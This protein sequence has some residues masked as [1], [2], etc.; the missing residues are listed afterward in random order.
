MPKDPR[1]FHEP[2]CTLTQL[3]PEGKDR[4]KWIGRRASERVTRPSRRRVGNALEERGGAWSRWNW[5]FAAEADGVDDS[6]GNKK[7]QS[8]T[9]RDELPFERFCCSANLQEGASREGIRPGQEES[10]PKAGI[11][12]SPVSL[13]SDYQLGDS[14]GSW[15]VWVSGG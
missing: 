10:I 3:H 14:Q 7:R 11:F 6:R 9:L 12:R 4:V 2:L 8:I 15:P 13:T 5:S 1:N